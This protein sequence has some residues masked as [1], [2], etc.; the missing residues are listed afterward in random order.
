VGDV[1]VKGTQIGVELAATPDERERRRLELA[2]LSD[3]LPCC[4]RA[5]LEQPWQSPPSTW[6]SP[7]QFGLAKAELQTRHV[8]PP[9]AG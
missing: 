6:A 4:C 3:T 1:G 7:R 8:H 5:R 2:G 9:D